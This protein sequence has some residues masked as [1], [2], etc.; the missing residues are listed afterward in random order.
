[1]PHCSQMRCDKTFL[2]LGQAKSYGMPLGNFFIALAG[3]THLSSA[4]LTKR[5]GYFAC[6]S[7]SG[8]H[9]PSLV[10]K[11]GIG[12]GKNL[13][14]MREKYELLGSEQ[15]DVSEHFTI[16]KKCRL[17]CMC[18]AHHSELSGD[19]CKIIFLGINIFC[20]CRKPSVTVLVQISAR[21]F[22]AWAKFRSSSFSSTVCP[23]AFKWLPKWSWGKTTPERSRLRGAM[24]RSTWLNALLPGAFVAMK[25]ASGFKCRCYHLAAFYNIISI[26]ISCRTFGYGNTPFG[27]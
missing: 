2:T 6:A 15:Q 11:R 19:F 1:M 25:R 18:L 24:R 14:L 8:Q 4:R 22:P 21:T 3:R 27:W 16:Y 17:S 26:K 13:S 10:C 20:D 9:K 7:S 5:D 12:D 23:C